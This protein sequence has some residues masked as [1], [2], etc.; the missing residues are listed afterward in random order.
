MLLPSRI[1]PGV[2]ESTVVETAQSDPVAGSGVAVQSI[3]TGY[4]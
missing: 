3:G 2:S 4:S 1:A